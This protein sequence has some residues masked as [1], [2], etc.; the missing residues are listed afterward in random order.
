[1]KRIALILRPAGRRPLGAPVGRAPKCRAAAEVPVLGSKAFSEPFGAGFGH[2][3]TGSDLQRRRPERR[4]P[5]NPLAQLGR[6]DRDRLRPQ[7]DLPARRAATTASPPGSSSAPPSSASATSSAAYTRLE[8]RAPKHPGGK[9]TSGCS[10]R[11]R[12]RS[13]K[14]L[15]RRRPPCAAITR[16]AQRRARAGTKRPS[17]PRWSTTQRYPRSVRCGTRAKSAAGTRPPGQ[18]RQRRGECGAGGVA[19]AGFVDQVPGGIALLG[20]QVGEETIR[21]G[22]AER[23]WTERAGAGL[24]AAS[25]LPRAVPTEEQRQ[26]EPAEAAVRVVDHR[27][28]C[29][30]LEGRAMRL[31]RRR[32]PVI[33]GA[34]VGQAARRDLGRRGDRRGHLAAGR[35]HRPARRGDR[36]A[37]G[38]R[39]PG[40]GRAHLL[41][42]P[43]AVHLG[44]DARRTT[45]RP[46]ARSSS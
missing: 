25:S 9:L 13:A 37:L 27:R 40:A 11:A 34:E 29:H 20:G 36:G 19:A 33:P 44:A 45:R 24:A 2:R 1:M 39:T 12:R 23:E 41:D 26:A 35:R 4:S 32:P 22:G 8:I 17:E 10:G 38:S 15:A 14:R 16:S 21:L 6:P 5:R 7:P 3:R 46:S 42:D 28:P 31:R 30:S 43:A 18:Q